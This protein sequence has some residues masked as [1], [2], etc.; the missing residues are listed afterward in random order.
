[1]ADKLLFVGTIACVGHSRVFLPDASIV[2]GVLPVDCLGRNA[3]I[4]LA[5]DEQVFSFNEVGGLGFLSQLLEQQ[6]HLSL[7]VGLHVLRHS[8]I[9]RAAVKIPKTLKDFC[10]G[11][12]KAFGVSKDI[13]NGFRCSLAFFKLSVCVIGHCVSFV[14][15]RGG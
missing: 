11:P 12:A 9:V 4:L 15:I 2:V 7:N 13:A 6:V 1:M 8:H 14:V 10:A 5:R 3:L